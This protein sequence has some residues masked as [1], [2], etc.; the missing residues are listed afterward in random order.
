M[1]LTYASGNFTASSVELEPDPNEPQEPDEE[2][3]HGDP[4]SDP[5]PDPEESSDK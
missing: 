2:E 1:P 5:E 4:P 3:P